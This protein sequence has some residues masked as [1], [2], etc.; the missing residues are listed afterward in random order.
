M[1]KIKII[2]I[3]KWMSCSAFHKGSPSIIFMFSF[4]Y[5]H[6]NVH[7]KYSFYL[8]RFC[9]LAAGKSVQGA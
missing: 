2:R 6:V 9:S 4:C 5:L 8:N 1:I 7:L 3:L